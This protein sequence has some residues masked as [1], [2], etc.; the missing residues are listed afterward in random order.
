M[1]EKEACFILK[2]R[3]FRITTFGLQTFEG[4]ILKQKLL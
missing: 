1:L 4:H 3:S 2:M